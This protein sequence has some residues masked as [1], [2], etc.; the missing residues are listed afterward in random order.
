MNILGP[1]P[2]LETERLL[3]RPFCLYDANGYYKLCSEK[4]VLA[5]TDMPHDISIEAAREWII[6]QPEAWQQRKELYML[7]IDKSTHEIVGSA[8]LFTYDRHN[9]ADLG[10]WIVKDK[11]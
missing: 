8:S 6:S 4:D 9:K 11:W 3:L 10:Y 7:A 5:G 1:M 2:R